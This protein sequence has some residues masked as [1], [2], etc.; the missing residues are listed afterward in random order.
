MLCTKRLYDK[1]PNRN[2]EVT[3]IIYSIYTLYIN[4]LLLHDPM[5]LYLHLLTHVWTCLQ[6]SGYFSCILRIHNKI[7]VSN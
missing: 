6:S 2:Y 3:N 7:A 5:A 1:K 4:I